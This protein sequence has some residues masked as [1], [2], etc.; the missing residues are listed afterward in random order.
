MFCSKYDPDV[1]LRAAVAKAALQENQSDDFTSK[2]MCL[3]V[4]GDMATGSID[5]HRESIHAQ[6]PDDPTHPNFHIG[7]KLKKENLMRAETL[8]RLGALALFPVDD[9]V[10]G[11]SAQIRKD[12]LKAFFQASDQKLQLDRIFSYEDPDIDVTYNNQKREAK[13]K[14]G[15]KRKVYEAYEA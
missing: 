11:E 10:I 3:E 15:K 4:L 1:Q 2:S 8:F 6:E 5:G 14:A 13:R 12:E 7:L 9:P